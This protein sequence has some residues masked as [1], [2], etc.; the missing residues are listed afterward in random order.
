[1]LLPSIGK[2]EGLNIDND[3]VEDENRATGTDAT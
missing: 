1:M 3:N 2:L